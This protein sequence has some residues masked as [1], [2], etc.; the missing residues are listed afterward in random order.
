MA[1]VLVLVFGTGITLAPRSGLALDL[2][3][4]PAGAALPETEHFRY[5][6]QW[7]AGYGLGAI[8]AELRAQAANGPVVVLAP[9]ASRERPGRVRF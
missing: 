5:V 1:Q 9:P 3:R 8:V 7:F 6:E 4:D 2:V